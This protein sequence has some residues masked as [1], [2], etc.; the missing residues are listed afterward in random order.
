MKKVD[1]KIGEEY[2]IG[3]PNAS[4]DRW[5]RV[6]GRVVK[7]GVYGVTRGDWHSH[8]ST[9]PN[10]VEFEVIDSDD[11]RSPWRYRCRLVKADTAFGVRKGGEDTPHPHRQDE[12]AYE[13]HRCLTSH[14][15]KSWSEYVEDLAAHQKHETEA[16]QR[17]D[18][19]E[20]RAT[21]IRERF[22]KLGYTAD[23][24][25]YWRFEFSAEDA[26]KILAVLERETP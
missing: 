20:A 14:V 25:K 15:L 13:S 24:Y 17:L 6:R 1:I 3:A 22:A 7:V 2:A 11:S 16:Q 18:D 21:G 12:D 5:G 8:M 4:Y 19:N 26:E 9:R 23:G 10:Y